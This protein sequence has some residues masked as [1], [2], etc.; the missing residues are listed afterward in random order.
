VLGLIVGA[1]SFVAAGCGGDDDDGGASTAI[2]GL[3]S[4]LEEIQENARA[5]GQVNLIAWSGY[6]EKD[7]VTPFEEQ[8][9]CKVSS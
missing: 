2:E 7:W 3:G 1:L 4:S 5:E 6:V 8:T 9:G